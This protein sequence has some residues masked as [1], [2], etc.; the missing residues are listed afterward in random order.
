MNKFF[1]KIYQ[2]ALTAAGKARLGVVKH[3]P[4]IMLVAGIVSIG[5]GFVMAIAATSKAD[6][7]MDAFNKRMDQIKENSALADKTADP[8]KAYSLAQRA[9]DKRFVY[10]H[11]IK[12]MA[13]IYLP[14]VMFEVAGILLI[15]KSH[16]VLSGR[17]AGVSA[18]LLAREKQIEEYRKR[19]REKYGE[20]AEKDIFYGFKTDTVNEQVTGDNG[21]TTEEEKKIKTA[22]PLNPYSRFIDQDSSI[23]EKSPQYTLQNI[24]VQQRTAND[25]LWARGFL[26]LNEV[27]R[28]LDLPQTTDGMI[29]GWIK[30][31]NVEQ[32]INFGL[33]NLNSEAIRRFV[34][35][36][37][38]V[39]LVDFNIDGNIYQM[40]INE[41]IKDKN[42]RKMLQCS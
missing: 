15:C 30:D 29:M 4:E 10:G 7:C 34:N 23:W 19:I 42:E 6:D 33:D 1:N 28:L 32:K 11:M 26:T 13:K 37:E 20:E 8:E 25:L 27:Y 31:P 39:V 41:R 9:E 36:Y 2:N 24:L 14:A 35:G 12:S 21:V 5:T 3:S 38:D 22:D 16:K 18:A 17:Y 40:K